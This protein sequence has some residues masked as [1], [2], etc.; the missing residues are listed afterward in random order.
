MNMINK[1]KGQKISKLKNKS[2]FNPIG[3][4]VLS[5]IHPAH[6][7]NPTTPTPLNEQNTSVV[8]LKGFNT[9]PAPLLSL[10]VFFPSYKP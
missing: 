2:K 6:K 7:P 8:V 10:S 4:G 1:P 5:K 9:I 3:P